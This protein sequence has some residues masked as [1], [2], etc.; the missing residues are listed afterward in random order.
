MQITTQCNY[1]CIKTL[2]LK[3]AESKQLNQW[4]EHALQVRG[5]LDWR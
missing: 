3:N 4:C 1:Y 5:T 2:S